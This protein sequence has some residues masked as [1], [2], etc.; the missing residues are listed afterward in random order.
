MKRSAGLFAHQRAGVRFRLW[1]AFSWAVPV[2]VGG[3]PDS[4]PLILDCSASWPGLATHRFAM[5]ADS[6]A[7]SCMR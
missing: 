4:M 5:A 7:Y 3:I 6:S 2:K 1:E